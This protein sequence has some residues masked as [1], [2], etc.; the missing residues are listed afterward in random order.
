MRVSLIIV[1]V[2]LIVLGGLNALDGAYAAAIIL[3]ACAAVTA[4]AQERF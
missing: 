4:I 3:A 2:T 1:S